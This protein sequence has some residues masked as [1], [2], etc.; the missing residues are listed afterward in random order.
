MCG[1]QITTKLIM[2]VLIYE[3]EQGQLV[4]LSQSDYWR[5][6]GRFS[7]K[8][9][10]VRITSMAYIETCNFSVAK[11]FQISVKKIVFVNTKNI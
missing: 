10:D 1:A 9:N 8:A 5:N 2:L 4:S 7:H 6:G 11:M 3:D